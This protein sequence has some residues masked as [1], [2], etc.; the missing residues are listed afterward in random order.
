MNVVAKHQEYD[1]IMLSLQSAL[2]YIYLSSTHR[3]FTYHQSVPCFTFS[4]FY[5]R[6]DVPGG[7]ETSELLID[8]IL[9]RLDYPT[10]SHS[11]LSSCPKSDKI[12]KKFV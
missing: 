2:H 8:K 6:V 10:T 12:F 9:Y 4:L 7:S 11:L 1:V 5:Q 3:H